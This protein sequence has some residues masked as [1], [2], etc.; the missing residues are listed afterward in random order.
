MDLEKINNEE[1]ITLYNDRKKRSEEIYNSA[2]QY[3]KNEDFDRAEELFLSLVKK[4]EF[5][6]IYNCSLLSLAKIY[7]KKNLIS[8]AVDIYDQI[9]K[10]GGDLIFII[11]AYKNRYALTNNKDDLIE[12]MENHP[13]YDWAQFELGFIEYKKIK[14]NVLKI[15]NY[16]KNISKESALFQIEN[17]R[18][19]LIKKICNLCG[20]KAQ[21]YF[22]TFRRVEELTDNL[23]IISSDEKF[24]DTIAHYTN[25]KVS[26]LLLSRDEKIKI[27]LRNH[28]YV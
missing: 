22:D 6:N 8:K 28:H 1:S 10:K 20:R 15:Y 19:N 13:L 2:S 21:N 16:W 26:K 3:L 24:E 18:I 25:I 27:L 12:I 17:Y 14:P 9:I 23:S 7:E 4:D 11:P 5:P